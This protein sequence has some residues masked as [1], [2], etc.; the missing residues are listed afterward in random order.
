[1]HDSVGFASFHIVEIR[2]HYFSLIHVSRLVI[3]GPGSTGSPVVAFDKNH[4]N[5]L[6]LDYAVVYNVVQDLPVLVVDNDIS[7]WDSEASTGEHI[8]SIAETVFVRF[9][10]NGLD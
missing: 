2:S 5:P 8:G 1:M 7:D 4:N 10:I 3:G 9:V 6:N